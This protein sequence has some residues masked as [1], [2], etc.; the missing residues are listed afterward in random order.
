MAQVEA[1]HQHHPDHQDGEAQQPPDQGVPV[2]LQGH[3]ADPLQR[4]DDA[5]R[6]RHGTTHEL[7]HRR[8]RAAPSHA[9]GDPTGL[10]HAVHHSAMRWNHAPHSRSA[11]RTALQT[12][13][14]TAHVEN[15][16]WRRPDLQQA[17]S[18]GGT[19]GPPALP[20][21]RPPTPLQVLGGRVAQT[22]R[23]G[24]PAP[25]PIPCR[26]ST[27]ATLQCNKA[28]AS[29]CRQ[30]NKWHAAQGMPRPAASWSRAPPVG[31]T[32]GSKQPAASKTSWKGDMTSWLT[33]GASGTAWPAH[34]GQAVPCSGL[35]AAAHGGAAAARGNPARAT[36]R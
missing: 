31:P 35:P 24:P 1:Q 22:A 30:G 6:Q 15:C 19:S 14:P 23:T 17:Q 9:R 26:A 33:S 32:R 29:R 10:W 13:G 36:Q 5:V 11:R 21:A 18:T 25:P 34:E 3:R 12:C 7:R 16:G 4:P 28:T 2:E 20:L 27:G 8:R